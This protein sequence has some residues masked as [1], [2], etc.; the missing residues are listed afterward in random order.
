MIV[1]VTV[2]IYGAVLGLT[3][4]PAVRAVVFAAISVAAAQYSAIYLGHSMHGP[5]LNDLA[6]AIQSYA[7]DQ[8]RDVAPNA[9]AAA[10]AAALAA[11][12]SAMNRSGEARRRGRRV[13]AIKD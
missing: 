7:G 6:S 13:A 8:A 10:F 11:I 2:A 4:R 3:T 5:S 9:S 1:I 12:I